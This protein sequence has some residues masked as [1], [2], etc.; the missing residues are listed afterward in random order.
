MP[1]RVVLED[2]DFE[3]CLYAV[4]PG[5]YKCEFEKDGCNPI[6]LCLGTDDSRE[7]TFCLKHYFEGVTGDGV[8]NY[9]LVVQDA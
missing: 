3:C 6:P 9:K 1:W 5:D 4:E 7:G 8:T 2:T